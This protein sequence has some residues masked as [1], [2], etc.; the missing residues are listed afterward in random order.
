MQRK[1]INENTLKVIETLL[2]I[3]LI[4]TLI[5]LPK[6]LI[7][8]ITNNF[9]FPIFIDVL[10]IISITIVIWKRF[11]NA[12]FKKEMPNKNLQVTFVILALICLL[13][14]FNSYLNTYRQIEH[15]YKQT[16]YN[17]YIFHHTSERVKN[18]TIHKEESDSGLNKYYVSFAEGMKYEVDSKVYYIIKGGFDNGDL[19]D[20]IS[21]TVPEK[22]DLTIG[23]LLNN[24]RVKTKITGADITWY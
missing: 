20:D 3:S 13:T 2:Y 21:Y 18:V 24:E 16:E 8:D 19:E 12:Y 9:Y 15:N 23:F 11:L 5:A 22:Y 6:Y 7:T 17:E 1:K 14:S 10:L 4:V